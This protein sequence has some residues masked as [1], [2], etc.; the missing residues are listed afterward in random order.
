VTVRVPERPAYRFGQTTRIRVDYEYADAPWHGRIFIPVHYTAIGID[1]PALPPLPDSALSPAANANRA[2]HRA[3]DITLDRKEQLHSFI[4]ADPQ[5]EHQR[6]R[7][8][9]NLSA[10]AWLGADAAFLLLRIEVTDNRHRQ[11]Q[12]PSALWKEDSVQCVIDVPGQNGV[13]KIDLADHDSRGPLTMIWSRPDGARYDHQPEI[14]LAVAKTGN[15]GQGRR[16]EARIPR[17][18]LGLTDEILREGF[19]FNIAVND[20]DGTTRAHALELVPGLVTNKSSGN[21]PCVMFGKLPE[22]P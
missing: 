1:D 14:H 7:G 10:R 5:L 9:E 22:K 21:F 6:W 19:R 16:Y 12:E 4:E 15:A 13:W 2:G 18:G 20:H 17:S 11:T 8:P 3:P